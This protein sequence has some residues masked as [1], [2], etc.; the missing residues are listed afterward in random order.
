[1]A[2][3]RTIRCANSS[4]QRRFSWISS[5]HKKQVRALFGLLLGDD[6]SRVASLL[7][8]MCCSII[9]DFLVFVPTLLK[10][11][12]RRASGTVIH[13]IHLS[14][15]IFPTNTRKPFLPVSSLRE[16]SSHP[17]EAICLR[18]P[19][20]MKNFRLSSFCQV[21]SVCVSTWLVVLKTT[22]HKLWPANSASVVEFKLIWPWLDATNT[23]ALID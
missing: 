5:R 17:Y 3:K 13:I 7:T 22:R 20:C 11:W 2:R 15:S 21:M 8:W 6:F 23:D 19:F 4:F 9:F 18:S 14:P 1:M 16:N 10:W 12:V